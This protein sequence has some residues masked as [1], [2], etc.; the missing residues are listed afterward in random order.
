MGHGVFLG[1]KADA[2]S[3]D[4]AKLPFYL[5]EQRR[6]QDIEESDFV[7]WEEYEAEALAA[8][9][10]LA[11]RRIMDATVALWLVAPAPLCVRLF[12]NAQQ[13]ATGRMWRGFET[14][15][16]VPILTEAR[17]YPTYDVR[18]VAAACALFA[19]LAETPS[20]VG[21]AMRRAL[22]EINGTMR[23]VNFWIVLE[24]LFG[25]ESPRKV[26]ARI[27]KRTAAFLE[28]P[29]SAATLGEKI[30]DA[31]SLRSKIVHGLRG[32][33]AMPPE[34]SRDKMLF[35]EGLARRSLTKI[36]SNRDLIARFLGGVDREAYL[37]ALAPS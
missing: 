36:L 7:F 25:P 5:G 8:E 15:P 16:A 18:Q 35:V 20:V 10:K 32:I 21:S 34:E 11:L 23:Y 4:L 31:Y 17:P 2:P 28:P 13:D 14:Y 24:A 27:A 3:L 12:V 9:Q 6:L 1:H 29:T 19:S 26:S 30:R 33:D 37:E 22:A